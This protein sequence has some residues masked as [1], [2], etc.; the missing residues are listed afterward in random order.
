MKTKTII[1][2]TAINPNHKEKLASNKQ[3][4]V[5]TVKTGIKAGDVYM[6]H[7]PGSSGR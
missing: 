2:A 1:K 4:K 6:H 7:P 5:F 3:S